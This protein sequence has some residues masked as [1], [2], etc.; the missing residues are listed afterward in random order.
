VK[1]MWCLAKED[2]KTVLNCYK[3]VFAAEPAG[4]FTIDGTPAYIHLYDRHSQTSGNCEVAALNMAYAARDAAALALIRNPMKRARS[5]YMWSFHANS[6]MFRPQLA[7]TLNEHLAVELDYLLEGPSKGLLDLLLQRPD[8]VDSHKIVDAYRQL[9]DGYHVWLAEKPE[10]CRKVS[11]KPVGVI[12][13][14]IPW[15]FTWP[16]LLPSLYYP[17]LLQWR[18]LVFRPRGAAIVQSEAYYANR[19]IL[20]QLFPM[21]PKAIADRGKRHANEQIYHE[22]AEINPRNAE[23]LKQFFELPNRRLHELLRMLPAEGV[24]VLPPVDTPGAWW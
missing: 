19:S 8:V 23:R 24:A 20:D 5:E 9:V 1:E 13:G 11:Q 4:K 22:D 15:C 3:K 12:S 17:L 14:T 2:H 7:S 18:S 21:S 6:G 10:L 16:V